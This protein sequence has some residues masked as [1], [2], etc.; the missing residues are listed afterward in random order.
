MTEDRDEICQLMDKLLIRSLELVQEEV[1]LKTYIESTTNDGQLSL[2]Q[3]RFYKGPTS[4]SAVQLPTEDSKEMNPLSALEETI[5]D[6]G[7]PQVQLVKYPVDK[8][9][10]YPDPIKWFGVLVPASLQKARTTFGKALDYVVDCANVQ[11]ELR[12][13]LLAYDQ[14]K[15]RKINL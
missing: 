14:L 3:T 12:N 8:E 13:V 2:A 7:N 1:K 11:M 9:A 6:V 10:G 4:V 15:E 5:D